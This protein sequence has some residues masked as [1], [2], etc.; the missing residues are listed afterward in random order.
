MNVAE[1]TVD[2]QPLGTHRGKVRAACDKMHVCAGLLQSRAEET[3][4]ASGAYDRDFH[5]S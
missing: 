3:A 1:R 2:A 5:C 4:D